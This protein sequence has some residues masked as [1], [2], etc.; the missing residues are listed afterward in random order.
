[1]GWLPAGNQRTQETHTVLS[2]PPRDSE[3][4]F[5]P[6]GDPFERA[7]AEA[8]PAA[9]WRD[10][11]VLVAVSGGGDSLALM[12]AL[13]SLARARPGKGG[14][15]VAHFNHALRG[16]E[17][18]GDQRLV[19]SLCSQLGLPLETDSAQGEARSE[20][21]ARDERYAFF[22]AAADRLGARFV[23]TA[24]TADDQVETV[25]FRLL[26]GAG[27]GGAAGTPRCRVLSPSCTVVRPMLGLQGADALAYLK[28]LGQ[29]HRHDSSNDSRH[30]TRNWLR[31][32]LLPQIR[33]RMGEGVDEAVLRFAEQAAEAQLFIAAE[34]ARLLELAQMPAGSPG[35]VRLACEPLSEAS[36][37]LAREA[38]KLAWRRAGWPEGAMAARHW[39]E[40]LA[41]AR[42]D[43]AASDM[44]GA[45]H[46]L[47]EGRGGRRAM[48]LAPKRGQ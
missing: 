43:S 3:A 39:A 15:I 33:E 42:G 38:I 14:L 28:R 27:L 25:L 12:R 26:R 37:L 2:H 9:E 44:P 19:A 32:E 30:F 48:V 47:V 20:E 45:I 23:A 35:A 40:L 24:H 18:Q 17:S 13:A 1:M 22:R 16:E 5:E 11:N 46:A 7:V 36:A 8:W 4:C 34:A 41:I 31:G 29:D 10:V 21:S 6:T